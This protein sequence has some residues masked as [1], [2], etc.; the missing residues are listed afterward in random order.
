MNRKNI[1]I[2]YPSNTLGGAEL[3][4]IR[5]VNFLHLYYKEI[6]VG[7]IGLKNDIAL[8]MLNENIDFICEDSFIKL[9]DNSI[10]ITHPAR[11]FKIPKII[12]KDIYFVFWILHIDELK[13]CLG[14][15]R[16]DF[17]NTIIQIE[18]MIKHKALIC[19]DKATEDS[20]IKHN[21]KIP[22]KHTV[23]VMLNDAKCNVKHRLLNKNEINIGWLGR[24][25]EDKIYALIN[26]LDNLEN[27]IIDK[28]SI[29]VHIIGSGSCEDMIPKHYK[30]F[31]ILMQGT[32]Q[33]VDLDEF[34]LKNIDLMFAMGTSMLEAEKLGIPSVL[35]FYKTKPSIANKFIWSFLLKDYCLGLEDNQEY[36]ND[37]QSLNIILNN[38]LKDTEFYSLSARKHFE[39]FLINNQIENFIDIVNNSEYDIVKLDNYKNI[40]NNIIVKNLSLKN[41]MYLK[42]YKYFRSKLKRKGLLFDD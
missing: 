8:S 30:N 16:I 29:K 15:Y 13:F 9:P 28:V 12:A 2:Y 18:K 24:L 32:I 20:V 33:P 17:E 27:I 40:R 35:T 41:K 11:C 22:Y 3:L 1:Y 14:E 10:V 23:P 21:L 7:Y 25:S 36:I 31:R 4:F 38:F 37:K 42:A 19:M 5:I 34:L 6:K 26:F 39:G